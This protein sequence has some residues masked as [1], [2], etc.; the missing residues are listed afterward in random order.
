[1]AAKNMPIDSYKTT[2]PLFPSCSKYIPFYRSILFVLP[3]IMSSC[4]FALTVLENPRQIPDSKFVVF[5]AQIWLG[6][7]T[8]TILGCLK[9]FNASNLPFEEVG[10]Y[11]V[12]AYVCLQALRSR[13]DTN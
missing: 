4:I 11:M 5:D 8:P 7:E 6:G 2:F 12:Y 1:M 10:Y 9:Y 3:A 13:L